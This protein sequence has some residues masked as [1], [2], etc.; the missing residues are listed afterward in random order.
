MSELCFCVATMAPKPVIP[1]PVC[2]WINNSTHLTAN[3]LWFRRNTAEN[4][5]GV[6]ASYEEL[7]QRTAAPILC[8]IHDDVICRELGW[9][10]RVLEEFEDP[11]V[12]V[13]GFG[14]ALRHGSDELYK[15]PYKLQQLGRAGYRSNVDDAEVH[16]E[17]FEDNC[18]VAVLDGF[19]LIV[20]REL[21]DRAGGWP[22]DRYPPHHCYD[23]FLCCLAH[24]LGYRVRL[25]GVRCHHLGGRTAL[26]PAY[27]LWA[28]RSKWGSD[29]AMHEAGHRL[30]YEDFRDVLPWS[31]V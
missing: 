18:D 3:H 20:R 27:Q 13:V 6:V 8:Y 11:K 22:H 21:L 17:R 29:Q 31:C 2:T 10:L 5:L 26:S 1:D 4:N 30:I 24:Q 25:C 28:E 16:G 7:R 23:Y 12:G 19:A 9:D 14:G 15:R